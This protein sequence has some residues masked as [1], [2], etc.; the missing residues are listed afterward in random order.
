MTPE[1]GTELRELVRSVGRATNRRFEVDDPAGFTLLSKPKPDVEDSVDVFL[2]RAQPRR[3]DSVLILSGPRHPDSVAEAAARAARIADG[4]PAHLAE[5]VLRP[6]HQGRHGNRSF[7]LY[8]R[9][10]TFSRNRWIRYAQ[11]RW[12]RSSVLEWTL[13]IAACSRR[14]VEEPKELEARFVEPLSYLAGEGEA[15]S[16]MR[17]AANEA[18]E[19]LEGSSF[20]PVSVAQHGDLWLDNVLLNRGWPARR[21]RRFAFSV[22]DW[23]ASEPRGY[24][25]IDFLR[26]GLSSTRSSS[27]I[28]AGLRAQRERLGLSL[29]AVLPH[30]CAGI[31]WLGTHRN[32]FP[33]RRYLALAETL[34]SSTARMAA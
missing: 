20:V 11:K 2:I 15:S 14:P 34:F 22:I 31:G 21:G 3:D 30:V 28:S 33:Y 32:S 18:V 24:P 19:M 1:P 7:A 5:T 12:I 6:D 17:R 25:F 9:L 4:L 16:A 13:E 27:W 26:Y 29:D 23:G 10:G 8:P